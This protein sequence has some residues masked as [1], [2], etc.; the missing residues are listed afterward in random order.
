VE[1]FTKRN[2]LRK[3]SRE[4]FLC[5]IVFFAPSLRGRSFRLTAAHFSPIK[6]TKTLSPSAVLV[7]SSD[8]VPSGNSA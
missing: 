6:S 8:S 7:F 1:R 4:I 5:V 3:L 2:A